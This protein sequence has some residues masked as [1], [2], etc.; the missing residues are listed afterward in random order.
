MKFLTTIAA[1]ALLMTT[2]AHANDLGST[3]ITWG[4]DTDA[5]WDFDAEALSI[6]T[7]PGL[8]YG[9]GGI[10]FSMETDLD[11]YKNDEFALSDAFDTLTFDLGADY[12]LG[13]GMSVGADTTWDIEAGEMTGTS[14]TAS[15]SF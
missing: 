5:K 14:V 8:A 11:V 15:F 1:A 7:T 3:G 13:G 2:A 10:E 6:V 4:V 9:I 12:A